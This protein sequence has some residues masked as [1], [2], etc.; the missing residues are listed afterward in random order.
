MQF[1]EK[2][3]TITEVISKED[4]LSYIENLDGA[5]YDMPFKGDFSTTV[6]RRKNAKKSGNSWFGAVIA[7]PE[8]YFLRYGVPVPEDRT[9]LCLKCPPDLQ[10]FLCAEYAGRIM[11][12][13]HMNKTHWISIVIY[14]DVPR[15][16]IEKL[17]V[18]S[19]DITK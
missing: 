9:V 11:P 19:Y 4:I 15:E 12:A 2:F 6:L 1:R 3:V 14:S 8:K 7:A 5:F 10:P 17:I 16:E 18:L 13:Y